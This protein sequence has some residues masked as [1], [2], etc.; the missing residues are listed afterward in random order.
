M[1]AMSFNLFAM[2]TTRGSA[3]YTPY[4]LE[5][6]FSCTA[7]AHDDL[8]ILID[9]DH[10][11]SVDLLR[12]YPRV[13]LKQNVEPLSF[14]A[15]VN[16]M[17]EYARA[18]N[19]TV[20]FL[21]NDLIFTPRWIEPLLVSERAI[22]S[23]LSNRELQVGEGSF[24]LKNSM[25]LAEYL[26]YKEELRKIG[27]RLQ[28]SPRRENRLLIY[29]FY[30]IKLPAAVYSELGLLDDGFGSGGGED[31]DYCLRAALH[32]IPL[33]AVASSFVLH[34]NGCSTWKVETREQ[35]QVRIAKFRLRF[36]ERWGSLL[37]RLGIGYDMSVLAEAGVSEMAQQGRF[38]EV[39]LALAARAGI[40]VRCY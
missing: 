29:P 30:C 18:K 7:L 16:Q 38:R 5:S 39:V 10:S 26:P 11:F 21:N 37:L 9:N 12:A 22:L 24:V 32:D 20:F 15:N 3:E 6:F 2:V 13:E 36:E 17:I 4:A 8:F 25:A 23:P 31:T 19:A 1:G 28:A 27:Q 14:A 34:F 35:E 40:D 33:K